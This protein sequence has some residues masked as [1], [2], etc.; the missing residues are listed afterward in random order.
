M[1]LGDKLPVVMGK[2]KAVAN[3]VATLGADGKLAEAQRPTLADYSGVPDTRTV[4]GKALSADVT[5]TGA[6]IE[7]SGTDDTKLDAAIAGKADTALSNLSAPQSALYNLGAKSN[8]NLLDNWYFVGGG[9]QQGGGQFPINQRGE[10][11]Y[12]SSGSART[13]SFDRWMLDPNNGSVSITLNSDGIR[14]QQIEAGNNAQSLSQAKEASFFQSNVTYTLSVLCKGTGKLQLLAYAN[15][16]QFSKFTAFDVTN[17][18][19]PYAITFTLPQITSNTVSFWIYPD[20]LGN[21]GYIDVLAAKLELGPTQT[22]AY[23]DEEGNWQLFELPDYGEELAKCQRYFQRIKASSLYMRFGVSTPYSSTSAGVFIPL[24]GEM[25]KIPVVSF[26]GNFALFD[27]QKFHPVTLSSDT[28]SPY[29]AI[30]TASGSTQPTKAAQL[31]AYN[32]STAYIDFSA[33]L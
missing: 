26:G 13:V 3:G 16:G 24:L 30:L 18:Y 9:S 15:D 6:D 1:A 33:D 10:T 11:E 22:L 27:G 20:V 2:E 25:R 31:L 17:D 29:N 12:N 32:D 7:V 4:N 23:Q 28:L 14:L 5:L 21:L 8:P 19:A